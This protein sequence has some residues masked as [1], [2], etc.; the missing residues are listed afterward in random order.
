[1]IGEPTTIKHDLTYT[2]LHGSL[3][4]QLP[5]FPRG[6]LISTNAT[7]ASNL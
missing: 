2:S 1:M 6:V 5:D 4:K 3:C 7:G